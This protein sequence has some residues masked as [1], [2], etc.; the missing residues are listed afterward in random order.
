MSAKSAGKEKNNE[1][2]S[3]KEEKNKDAQE[4][5]LLP[6]NDNGQTG[7]SPRPSLSSSC[8]CAYLCYCF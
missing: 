1:K 4:A 7:T 2:E 3:V 8:L 6:Q 5:T